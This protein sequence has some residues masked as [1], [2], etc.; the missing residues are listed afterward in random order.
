MRSRR[1]HSRQAPPLGRRRRC[2]P[3][4]GSAVAPLGRDSD[5]PPGR[6]WVHA[7]AAARGREA[8]R[9]SDPERS[10]EETRWT[11]QNRKQRSA[12]LMAPV[13]CATIP[14]NAVVQRRRRETNTV[15]DQS[16]PRQLQH[17]VDQMDVLDSALLRISRRSQHSTST[18]D[19]LQLSMRSKPCALCVQPSQPTAPS[20]FTTRSGGCVSV[21]LYHP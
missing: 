18:D 15:T 3:L 5:A 21:L 11:A 6:A 12:H 20:R 8:R 13:A 14:R 19:S 16:A 4:P 7:A 10:K 9:G 2:A 17:M 1:L